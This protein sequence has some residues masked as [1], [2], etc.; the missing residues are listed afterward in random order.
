MAEVVGLL[1]GE[2]R[3]ELHLHFDGVLG[4]VCEAQLPRDTDAVGVRNHHA[5][6][7]IYIAQDQVGGLAA[8]AG[9]LQQVLHI[10]GHLPAELLQHHPGGGH[11]VP[12]LGTEKAGGVDVLL[13]L[14]HIGPGQGLQGGEAAEQGG[15][16]LVDA[17][18][19]ALRGQP[20]R[21]QQLIGLGVVQGTDP[22]RI[23]F[24]QLLYDGAHIGF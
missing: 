12:C 14:A 3:A 13:H 1:R 23:E 5:G 10:V 9:Q 16:H 2:H 20:D 18:I 17:L 8:H 24:F 11:D 19:G 4:A 7:M 15:G 6:H 21:E 22:F